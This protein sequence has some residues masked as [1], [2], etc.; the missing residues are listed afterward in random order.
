MGASSAV[1]GDHTVAGSTWRPHAPKA[2][3]C[4]SPRHDSLTPVV[5]ENLDIWRL[6]FLNVSTNISGPISPLLDWFN[7]EDNSLC[8]LDTSDQSGVAYWIPRWKLRWTH[9]QTQ[10]K[11][12]RVEWCVAW[13]MGRE[14]WPSE[15]S[16]S[17]FDL[18][19]IYVVLLGTLVKAHDLCPNCMFYIWYLYHIYNI[20]YIIAHI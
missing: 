1:V 7:L 3:R 16:V 12:A 8:S 14:T 19:D 13:A 15:F 17:S 11:S 10:R 6:G 2:G 9:V 20:T 5:V 18:R 4:S